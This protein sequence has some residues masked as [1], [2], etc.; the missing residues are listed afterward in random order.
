MT[1]PSFQ[2][3]SEKGWGSCMCLGVHPKQLS[4]LWDHVSKQNNATAIP[5]NDKGVKRIQLN[6]TSSVAIPAPAGWKR[7]FTILFV[8]V[9]DFAIRFFGA[10]LEYKGRLGRSWY[11]FCV[12]VAQAWC[13]NICAASNAVAA[14]T[15]LVHARQP[16][17]HVESDDCSKNATAGATVQTANDKHAGGSS[18]AQYACPGR[19][20]GIDL[21]CFRY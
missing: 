11:G 8:T 13:C 4:S 20:D 19:T 9:P 6:C 3:R 17:P 16:T 7:G 1:T 18:A 15:S 14:R 10:T 2:T 12:L 21:P 5:M